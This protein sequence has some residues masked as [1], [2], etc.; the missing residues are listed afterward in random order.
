MGN[1]ASQVTALRDRNDAVSRTK[2]ESHGC[3][4][5]LGIKPPRV[6][7]QRDP[8]IDSP[9]NAGAQRLKHGSPE[10]CA[11]RSIAKHGAVGIRAVLFEVAEEPIWIAL[12]VASDQPV[13]RVNQAGRDACQ[14]MQHALVRSHPLKRSRD[15][16]H[17]HAA[18]RRDGRYPVAQPGG[19]GQRVRAAARVSVGAEALE[20]ETVG[21][22]TD[23]VWPSNHPSA[24]LAIR[25]T[26]P[27]PLD[28]DQ[29]NPPLIGDGVRGAHASVES[30]PGR[31][32]EKHD[33]TPLRGTVERVPDP[34]AIIE[35]DTLAP[36]GHHT[37]L[38]GSSVAGTAQERKR[39]ARC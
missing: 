6:A 39:W 24:R 31:A 2:D 27:G 23:I 10:P 12:R 28:H 25:Q 13:H 34:P 36:Y 32:A 11:D 14:T 33:R 26:V 4:N 29:P 18:D 19:A 21:D 38:V 3:A 1:P 8:V 37:P 20:P 35:L 22:L 17:T 16:G 5:F 15:S 9:T 30:R 7:D